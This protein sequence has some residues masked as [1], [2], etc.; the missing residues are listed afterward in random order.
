MVLQALVHYS[1]LDQPSWSPYVIGESPPTSVPNNCCMRNLEKVQELLI[2]VYLQMHIHLRYKICVTMKYKLYQ[3]I[4]NLLIAG[5][6][7][8]PL[9]FGQSWRPRLRWS[10]KRNASTVQ[11]Y[12]WAHLWQGSLL[13]PLTL[14]VRWV[15]HLLTSHRNHRNCRTSTFSN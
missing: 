2:Q 9:C 13:S 3:N 5:R 10:V 14:N 6:S 8:R 4:W 7:D 1:E 12:V 15:K 11:F